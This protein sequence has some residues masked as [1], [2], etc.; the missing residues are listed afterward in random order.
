MTNNRPD[1]RVVYLALKEYFKG[2]DAQI[3]KAKKVREVVQKAQLDTDVRDL[4]QQHNTDDVCNVA[5]QTWGLSSDDLTN[6]FSAIAG[7]SDGLPG[8][9]L[10][11]P[12]PIFLGERSVSCMPWISRIL[13]SRVRLS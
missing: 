2:A 10:R 4:I 1:E 11:E 6:L 5:T 7:R 8:C 12:D 3:R 13:S 9:S